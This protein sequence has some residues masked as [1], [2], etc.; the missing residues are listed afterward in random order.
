MAEEFVKHRLGNFRMLAEPIEPA[1]IVELN[2][3]APDFEDRLYNFAVALRSLIDTVDSRIE[4]YVER[5]KQEAQLRGIKISVTRVSCKRKS[6]MTCL[7]QYATHYP[8]F[9]IIEDKPTLIGRQGLLAFIKKSDTLR[10]IRKRALKDFL[11]SI[12]IE[13]ERIKRFLQLCDF[14]D[15]L[16]ADYHCQILT[17][18]WA[19]LSTIELV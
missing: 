13:E 3:A 12:G 14:R 8:Y 4:R 19:G 5:I 10:Y 11:R 2:K 7:G 1:L 15:F 9:R 17:F 6:C 16:V 18:K